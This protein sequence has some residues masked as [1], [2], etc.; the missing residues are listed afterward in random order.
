MGQAVPTWSTLVSCRAEWV[1]ML[2][3]ER[4]R[5]GVHAIEA[6]KFRIRYL[7]TVTVTE[8][9]RV[10]FDG[11]YYKIVGMAEIDRRRGLE[12]AVELWK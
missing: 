6:G 7:S 9:M 12:L 10:L 1:P 5:G 2:A 8:K 11:K 4:F 3:G